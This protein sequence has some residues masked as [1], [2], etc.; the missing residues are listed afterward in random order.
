M[1]GFVARSLATLLLVLLAS[2]PAS[3]LN[4]RTKKQLLLLDPTTRLE[5]I[6]DAGAMEQ[7]SRDKNP[8]KADRVVAY[9][10]EQP[11]LGPNSVN[12]P[13]AAFRSRGE[14]YRLSF[15]CTTDNEHLEIRALKYVIGERVPREQWE[16]H[17]LYD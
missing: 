5:Q 3:A 8:Y 16:Q 7:I 17:Q 15:Q 13:G 4:Q 9:A 11:Q 10:F 1:S 6:C 12:A 2:A 14:W